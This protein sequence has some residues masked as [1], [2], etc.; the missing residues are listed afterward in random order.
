MKNK[1]GWGVIIAAGLFVLSKFKF[2]LVIL[3]VLKFQTLISMAVY[4][5]MYALLFGWKFAVA[6]VY[7]IFIHEMGHT[8]AARKLK[9]PVSPAIFIPFVGAAISMKEM[10]KNAKDEAYL[11]YMGPV[12]G[13]LA[14]LPAIPLYFYSGDSFW[15]LVIFLGGLINLFNLIPI[16]PLDGGRIAAGISTKLWAIGLIII[17]GYSIYTFSF[18]AFII[19]IVG[20]TTW[21]KIYKQQK[22]L[23]NDEKE[24]ATYIETNRLLREHSRNASSISNFTYFARSFRSSI[25]NESLRD[26]FD[27]LNKV[28]DLETT[29]EQDK[30]YINE[31]LLRFDEQVQKI[32]NEYEQTATYYK[33]DNKTKLKLFMIYLGLAVFLAASTYFGNAAIMESEE[34]KT[35]LGK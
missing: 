30:Y 10:P 14:F 2:V 3:K 29:E 1:K 8:Y 13:L 34:M 27:I 35:I 21:Y 25:L 11:A 16:T 6:L 32:K 17:L 7:L 15:A 20:A 33:T 19:T 28:E 24:V 22:N 9:L 31:F 18:L 26:S 5:W 12:F 4:L 23:V